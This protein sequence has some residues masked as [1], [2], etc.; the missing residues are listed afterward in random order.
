[1][2]T[3]EPVT[4]SNLGSPLAKHLRAQAAASNAK[5]DITVSYRDHIKLEPR[6]NGV[7]VL[8]DG[9]GSPSVVHLNQDRAEWLVKQL[10]RIFGIKL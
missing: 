5:D 1:M 2:K 10:V 6:N 8:P 7:D 3:F 9:H 4:E